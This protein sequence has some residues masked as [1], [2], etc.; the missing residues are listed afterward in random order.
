MEEWGGVLVQNENFKIFLNRKGLSDAMPL[1]QCFSI[2]EKGS[3][4]DFDPYITDFFLDM[5]EM[6]TNIVESS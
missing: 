4:Q 5:R 1:E 2:I 3:G 6:I